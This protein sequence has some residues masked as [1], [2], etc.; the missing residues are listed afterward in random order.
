MRNE[1]MRDANKMRI[2]K[3]GL[4]WRVS[5]RFTLFFNARTLD[6]EHPKAGHFPHVTGIA[7]DPNNQFFFTVLM[8]VADFLML[9]D[10]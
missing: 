6:S 2:G 5:T 10:F 7:S 8:V 4:K 1:I 3:E 9:H